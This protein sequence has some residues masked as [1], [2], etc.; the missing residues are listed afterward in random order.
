LQFA[1]SIAGTTST[2]VSLNTTAGVGPSTSLSGTA[3]QGATSA[4]SVSA[5][6]VTMLALFALLSLLIL[7]RDRK[8]PVVMAP[9]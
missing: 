6:A 2:T 1:P 8:R 3:I 9:L 5:P 7:E 4:A